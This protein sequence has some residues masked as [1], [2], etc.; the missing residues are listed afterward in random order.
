MSDFADLVTEI[1]A[2]IGG[3]PGALVRYAGSIIRDQERKNALVAARIE[4]ARRVG[5][6][7]GQAAYEASKR[8]GK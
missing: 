3:V 7:S 2:L 4:R 8:A 1:G 6:A 5:I